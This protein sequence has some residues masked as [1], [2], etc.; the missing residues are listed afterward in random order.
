MR[1]KE[2]WYSNV[3]AQETIKS[4]T[5]LCTSAR[6]WETKDFKKFNKEV[7][8]RGQLGSVESQLEPDLQ[9]HTYIREMG[10]LATSSELNTEQSR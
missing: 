10:D 2:K 4:K 5:E 9:Q 1:E 8:S 7:A 3:K 6:T